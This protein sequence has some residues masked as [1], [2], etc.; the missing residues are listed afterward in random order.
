LIVRKLELIG[1]SPGIDSMAMPEGLGIHGRQV[2]QRVTAEYDISDAGGFLMLDQ[3]C[4]AVDGA[5]EYRAII[6]RDGPMI[7][8]KAGG[9]REHPLIKHEMIARAFVVRELQR[10]G[11]QFEPL[12]ASGRPGR[13]LGI[14]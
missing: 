6:D 7:K 5:A 1:S 2:W 13:P 3:I 8:S 10:L 12:R 4:R 14:A 11:L 9:A